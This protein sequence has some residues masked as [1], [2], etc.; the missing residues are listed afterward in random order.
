[1]KTATT[2]KHVSMV[3]LFV[4][5]FLFDTFAIAQTTAFTYQGRLTDGASPANGGHDFM[6][7]L[8]DTTSV[9][10]GSQHGS[11]LTVSNVAVS[12]GIFTVQ[13]D[14]GVCATCFD[15]GP[16][17]LEI[18]VKPANGATFS[19]LGPRQPITSAPYA[20]KSVT[21]DG[22]SVA[23][24]SCV[25]SSQ[26]ASVSGSAVIGTI[27]AAS[28]PAG[29]ASYIQ[30]DTTQQATS[31]FNIS[32]NGTVGGALNA[33]VVNAATHYKIAD[34]RVLSVGGP[35]TDVPT[36]LT[37]TASNTFVGEA[38]GLS[39]TPDPSATVFSGKA[40]SFFGAFA[41][42]ENTVGDS[43]SF[44]GT[45]AGRRSTGSNNAFFG[46]VAGFSN[47]TG[48][49]NSFFGQAA[50]TVATTASNNAF[51]GTSAGVA[52]TAGGNSFFGAF[53]G[54]RNATGSE[55]VF[56]GVDA[57]FNV[58]PASGNDNTLIGSHTKVTTGVSHGT[59]IGA[60]ATVTQSNSLILGS[61]SGINSGTD[62]LV[63]IGTTAPTERLHVDGNALV[64]G[65]V[66]V[67]GNAVVKAAGDAEIA[68]ESTDVNGRQWVVQSSNGAANG[69]FEVIDRTAGLTRVSISSSGNVGLGTTAP[70][71]KLDVN[72][73]IRVG[74]GLTG[75]VKDSDGTIIAGTCASD[76]RFK[77]DI[78][79][80]P[81]LLDQLVLLQPVQFYWRSE[82]F[83]ARRFGVK[84]SFGLIAQEVEKVMPELVTEDEEG[85]KALNY[86]KLP[87]LL[88][89]AI[90]EQ[91]TRID[92]QTKAL[93]SL[94][95]EN[96]AMKPR[97]EALERLVLQLR[98]RR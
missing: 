66:I 84:P 47:K 40:N 89:A 61:I 82:E 53:T 75:C 34:L 3:L 79:A 44:F 12:N 27:P 93:S 7:G 6:I 69:R 19:T 74:T 76:A 8:F 88:L 17:F 41:G 77:R 96:V 57:D 42:N 81:P 20:L 35:Y 30:N 50:G 49:S 59:A 56:I 43:N 5:G 25:T 52:T 92:A 78:T 11:T 21:A 45:A 68:L 23:C 18:A 90:K 58:S 9:G 1:M 4:T 87:L 22:L 48:S 55:N 28:V 63:G 14:F 46:S 97:L 36:M 91:Q 32:G 72:G 51:F 85:F 60:H 15:G 95:K 2:P 83:K 64:T 67:N 33:N 13:L 10:T 39:T 73:E 86:S 37:L 24:L 26:I 54:T 70:A 98:P 38:A 80:F 94:R 29:S 16:R 62:T 65:D 31:N 71:D